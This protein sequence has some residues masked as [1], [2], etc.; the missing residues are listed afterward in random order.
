MPRLRP[1]FSLRNLLLLTTSVAVALALRQT[2]Q[3]IGPM[4]A[5]I[6][7]LR[8]EL[9]YLTIEHP[10]KIHAL[11][12]Q[13]GDPLTWSWRVYLPPG[14][15][16]RIR[17]ASGFLPD[18]QGPTFNAWRAL[19]QPMREAGAATDAI[20]TLREFWF[21]K[22]CELGQP[23]NIG[24][25]GLNGEITLEAQLVQE[26]DEWRLQ[27]QPGGTAPIHQPNGDWL[28][29]GRSRGGGSSDVPFSEQTAYSA[30]ERIV[31]LHVRRPV[32]K[33]RPGS[34]SATSPTGDA[35]SIVLWL[36]SEPATR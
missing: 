32:I 36:E 5:E 16:Y 28:S 7:Q 31:L 12:V 30:G 10:A 18:Q 23:V 9:G 3:R 24:P 4:R 34:W 35:D 26:A 21:G 13:T 2:R 19:T 29:D 8:T 11:Q 33:E 15:T 27:L 25:A 1:R 20:P 14:R 22:V 17:C 6:A